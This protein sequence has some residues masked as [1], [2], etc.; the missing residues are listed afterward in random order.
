MSKLRITIVFLGAAVSLCGIAA[1]QE[2]ETTPTAIPL[3]DEPPPWA[4]AGPPAAKLPVQEIAGPRQ[5]LE[6]LNIDAS[7]LDRFADGRPLHVDEYEP[8]YRILYRIPRFQRRELYRWRLRDVDWDLLAEQPEEFR[9]SSLRITGRVKRIEKEELLPEAAQILEFDHF[10]RLS[11]EADNAPFPVLVC[12]RWL[13]LKWKIGEDV[14]YRAAVD[15]LF[16]KLGETE[17]GEPQ[18]IMVCDR[19][20]WHPDQPDSELGVTEDHV[21]LA[22]KGMDIGQFD[23]V[24]DRRSITALERECFYQM[25]DAARRIDPKSQSAAPSGEEQLG[26]LLQKPREVRGRRLALTGQVRRVQEIQVN[27]RDIGERFN[28][29]RYYEVDVFV[30]LENQK[31]KMGEGENA[32]LFESYFPVVYCVA[33]LPKGMKPEDLVDREVRVPAFYFKIWAYETEFMRRYGDRPTQLSPMLIGR[34]PLVLPPPERPWT[35]VGTFAA[36]LF[37][38]TLGVA[39]VWVWQMHKR[40]AIHDR[41]DRR[42]RFGLDER[43]PLENLEAETP[44]FSKLKPDGSEGDGAASPDEKEIRNPKQ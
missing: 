37:V 36:A 2:Q 35:D 8:L 22:S 16:L 31:I 42:R 7:Q 3:G 28:I 17:G 1:A 12:S 25:L 33:Q 40:D 18:L 41:E 44:D 43:K 27:E 11:L 30:P 10:Y 13:P 6:L 14:N 9:V 20:A 38:F 19:V 24:L 29:D 15:G 39:W 5:Y 23:L 26:P 34:Q 21:L 32:P 4:R